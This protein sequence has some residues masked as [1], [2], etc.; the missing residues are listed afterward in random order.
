MASLIDQYLTDLGK[1]LWGSFD[2]KSSI[3]WEVEDHLREGAAREQETGTLPEEAQ[4]RAIV[5]FGLPQ[6]V[7]QLFAAN[8]AGSGGNMW[9][10]FTER[11]R[12]VV[13]FAQGEA[14]RHRERYV[15]TEHLLLGLV[16]QDN[17]AVRILEYL[18]VSPIRLRGD[19]EKQVSEGTGEIGEMQLTPKSKR[20]IDLAYEESKAMNHDYIGTEHLL[21]GLLGVEDGLAAKLLTELGVDADRARRGFQ[22][23]SPIWSEIVKARQML[24]GNEALFRALV[25][26]PMT[27]TTSTAVAGG[28]EPEEEDAAVT[29]D[30]D[31]EARAPGAAAA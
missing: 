22:A 4:R 7:A 8:L 5:R 12:N 13:F 11:A 14:A 24:E 18:G 9:Q 17:L 1:A 31:N 2:L 10:Q 15:G 28:D 25:A 3:L 19:L 21:L 6:V 16:H 23:V 26:G 29:D 30:G 20:A 27:R